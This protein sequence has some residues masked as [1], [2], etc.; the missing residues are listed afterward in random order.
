M[1]KYGNPGEWDVSRVTNMSNLFEGILL[2]DCEFLR[3]WNV[4]NVTDM[5][6]M[7]YDVI[8]L[9]KLD[10]ISEWNISNVKNMSCMFGKSNMSVD[11][12][13][14]DISNVNDKES[15]FQEGTVS[16]IQTDTVFNMN[17]TN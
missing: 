1:K 13:L 2:D 8:G 3:S 14:W 10:S 17:S 12:S 16:N 4:S 11:I 5:N 9:T 6:Y 15:M 7:F